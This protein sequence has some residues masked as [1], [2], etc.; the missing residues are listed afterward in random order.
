MKCLRVFV[1]FCCFCNVSMKLTNFLKLITKKSYNFFFSK[2]NQ[3]N[4]VV[5]ES[6]TPIENIHDII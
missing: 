6:S 1:K 2:E 5:K 4:A 3:M